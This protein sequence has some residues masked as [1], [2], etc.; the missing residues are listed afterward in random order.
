MATVISTER[1]LLPS[2]QMLIDTINGFI[3]RFGYIVKIGRTHTQ[4][5]VPITF[6]QEFSA[7]VSQLENSRLRIKTGLKELKS[8][9]IG[10][11]A[12]GTGLNT[13]KNFDRDV[14]DALEEL[15]YRDFQP[16]PNKFE[17]ISSHDSIIRYSGELTTLATILY[18]LSNDIRFLGSGPRCGLG[19]L[20]LPENEPG[21]SIM[22][23][24]V[25]PTQCEALSMIC[26][27]TIG[28]N[29]AIVLGG[30]QGHF[31]VNA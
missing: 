11:T 7:Y 14:C 20:K 26:C 31:Q 22:P 2:I 15:S 18:K 6:S 9:A 5:A 16:A 23:G 12:V 13:Y 28:N 29:Q 19:E 4:D 25:N 27:Q 17:V 8:L 3:N 21:S 24:K 1:M 10:G 30:S